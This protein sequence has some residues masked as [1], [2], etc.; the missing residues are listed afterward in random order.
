VHVAFSMLLAPPF[1]TGGRRAA[2]GALALAALLAAA[3]AAI[4]APVA[5]E[6]QALSGWLHAVSIH[7][8]GQ[9]DIT[10]YW[11]TDDEGARALLLIDAPLLAV[12]GGV[13]GLDRQRVTVRGR[14]EPSAGTSAPALAVRAIEGPTAASPSASLSAV[15]QAAVT[16]ARPWVTLLCRFADAMSA[17]PHDVAWFEGLVTSTTYPGLAHYWHQASYGTV[18]LSGSVVVPWKNLPLPRSAYVSG[19]GF[20]LDRLARDCTA[21]AA[22]DVHFPAFFGINLMFNGDLPVSIGGTW[23]LALDGPA[24]YYAVTWIP[25]WG[26]GDQALV[27]HEMGHG[28]GLPHSSGPYG[29]TYDSRWDVMSNWADNCRTPH[30][31][32]G[33]V[34]TGTIAHHKNLAGWIPAARRFVAAAGTRE[35][36]HLDRLDQ[37]GGGTSYLMAVIPV[38]GSPSRSYTVEARDLVGYDSQLPARAV[39]I[40]RIDTTLQDSNAQVV[41]VD[42][43]RDPNDAAAMWLPGETFSDPANGISVSIVASTATGF[44]VTIASGLP[45]PVTAPDLVVAVA[46]EPPPTAIAGGR[47]RVGD[48]VA[49]RGDGPARTSR[50]RYYLSAASGLDGAEILMAG[51]RTAKAL[52]AGGSSRGFA[53]LRVPPAIPAG[54]YH[55]VTCADDLRAVAEHDEDNNCAASAAAVSVQAPDLAATAVSDP[56]AVAAPGDRLRI[57]DSIQNR[58]SA[59]AKASRVRYYLSRNAAWSSEATMLGGTR[60]VPALGP[61]ATS[62]GTALATIASSTASGEYYVFACADA[63]AAVSEPIETNN[64]HRSA[65]KVALGP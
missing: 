58:G 46:A 10:E 19:G 14:A 9:A 36:I 61:G 43:D 35:T 3:R 42:R 24:R 45:T 52:S 11:L 18:T 56:P 5:A 54:T 60:T 1:R 41:D 17:T 49:N 53:T 6:E 20:D 48:T 22:A 51:T 29:Q 2:R 44:E 23:V 16:G 63:A 30:P 27:A 4:P 59:T 13:R 57:T 34:G 50:I 31:V 64:C 12:H 38:A 47:F 32:Y 39:I 55:L 62:T 8:P 33:C 26:Y 37:P 7:R 65:R 25:R 15:T 40:H 28:F 21:A